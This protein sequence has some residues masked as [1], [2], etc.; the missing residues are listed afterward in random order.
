MPTPIVCLDFRLR[1]FVT[2]FRTCFTRPQWRYFVIVLLALMQC[3]EQRT[4]SG[5]GRQVAESTSLAGLSRFLAE[6]PWSAESVAATWWQRFRQQLAPRIEAERERLRQARAKRRGRP[7]TPLVT[8]YWIG[9]DSTQA[10][11]KGLKMEGLGRHHSTTEGKRIV[12]HSLVQGLY[13]LLGRRCP[14]A[15]QLYR[16]HAVCEAE[17]VTFQSKI[18][19]MRALIQTFEPLPGTRTHVLLDAWYAAKVIWRTARA[20]GFQI[21][22]GM[23]ANRWLRVDDPSEAEGWRWQKFSDYAAS[24]SEADYSIET[25]PSQTEPRPVY[26][27]TVQT[28]VRKL[29]RAQVVIVRESLS[30]PLSEARYF[31]SSDLTADRATLVAHLAARWAIEVLFADSKAELGL[32]HYQLMRATALVRFWT[33]VL[34]AYVFLDEERDRLARQVQ[35]HVTLGEARRDVQARHRRQLIDWLFQQFRHGTPPDALYPRLAA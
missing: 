19:L 35:H 18:E 1:Q 13:V 2:T 26:V 33:L 29:Y 34:T 28:R 9:D 21:T 14:L 24:L 32:D 6:A 12:G 7:K 10:K 4:L 20:R 27:H 31:A 22:T 8:G 15:P 25:W 5:L 17:G 30:A 16:Q 11:R 23:K 3:Q